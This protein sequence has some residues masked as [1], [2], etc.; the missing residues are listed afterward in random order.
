MSHGL[1]DAQAK[2]SKQV[3]ESR[4]SIIGLLAEA[5]NDA[6]L[7]VEPHSNDQTPPIALQ[8]L[9]ATQQQWVLIYVL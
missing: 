3:P 1:V 6:C 8:H 7:G 2:G 4:G 9:A 5:C